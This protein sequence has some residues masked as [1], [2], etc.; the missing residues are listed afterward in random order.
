MLKITFVQHDGSTIDTEVEPGMSIMQA[1]IENLV[2]GIEGECGGSGSCATCHCYLSE[3]WSGKV[4]QPDNNESQMLELVNDTT[5][6]S[7]L[8]CQVKITQE[9]HGLSVTLPESQY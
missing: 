4:T 9:H 5:A 6:F 7:R 3:Q 8:S 2:E 1:A